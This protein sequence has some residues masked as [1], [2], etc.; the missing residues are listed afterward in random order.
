MQAESF[1]AM[2]GLSVDWLNRHLQCIN[3]ITVQQA[4]WTRVKGSKQGLRPG[5][6]YAC[7]ATNMRVLQDRVLIEQIP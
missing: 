3:W 2:G 5:D 7:K 1:E 6:V 4:V